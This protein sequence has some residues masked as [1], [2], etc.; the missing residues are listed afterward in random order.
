MKIA[1][2]QKYTLT[3]I[4]LTNKIFSSYTNIDGQNYMINVVRGRSPIKI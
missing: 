4:F 1:K 2:M 3:I